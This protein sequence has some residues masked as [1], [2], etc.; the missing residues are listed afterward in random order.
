MG[1]LPRSLIPSCGAL[2]TPYLLHSLA[3][4][5]IWRGRRF[6]IP[7]KADRPHRPFWGTKTFLR[8]GLLHRADSL[9]RR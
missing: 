6:R 9:A 1:V 4:G 2:S 3:G 7:L 8:L 5:L